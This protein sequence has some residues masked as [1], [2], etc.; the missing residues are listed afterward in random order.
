MNAKITESIIYIG[1]NDHDIDLFEGQYIVP[2][3]MAYNSY[4]VIGDKIAIMDTIDKRKTDEWLQN[5][6]AAI[7]CDAP[8]YLVVQH[9]EPDHSAS[10]QAFVEKFRSEER[11]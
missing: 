10:I 5:I 3:G 9:M 1:A 8:D 2:N 7:K 6:E 4:A 11:R